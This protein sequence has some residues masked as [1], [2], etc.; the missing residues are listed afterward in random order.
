MKESLEVRR[1]EQDARFQQQLD[2][3]YE[4]ELKTLMREQRETMKQIELSYLAE[5][6]DIKRSTQEKSVLYFLY[7]L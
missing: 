6:Q 7:N 5:E 3:H 1:G 2:N 4:T